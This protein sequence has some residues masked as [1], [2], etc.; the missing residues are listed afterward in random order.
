MDRSLTDAEQLTPLLRPYD[1]DEL[2]AY[3]VSCSVGS[4]RND[5]ASLIEPFEAGEQLELW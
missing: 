1:A 3:A 2:E 5:D 4:V